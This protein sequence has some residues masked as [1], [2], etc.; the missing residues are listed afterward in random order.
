MKS[1]IFCIAL[2]AAALSV[3]AQKKISHSEP[4]KITWETNPVLH[5]VPPEYKNEPAF[6]LIDDESLD[7]RYEGGNINVYYTSHYLVKVLNDQGIETFNTRGIP[8][9]AGTRVPLIKARTIMPDGKVADV[10]KDMI[11]VT[12]D[13]YGRYKIVFAME[14]VA[15]NAEIEVLINEIKP[16]SFFGS[17]YFQYSI[18]V[19]HSSFE[20]S[21][22]KYM[23]FEEKGY[24]GYPTTKDTLLNN[25]RHILLAKNNIP[26]LLPEKHSYYNLHRMRAEYRIVNFIDENENDNKK[27]FTWNDLGRELYNDHY[28]ITDKEKKAVNKYL[29][30]LGAAPGAKEF[31]NIKKIENGIKTGIVLY[32]WLPG[33][34]ADD[35]DTIIAK[36]SATASGYIK[37]FNACFAQ[38]GVNAQL[39][40]AYDRREHAFDSKFENWGNLDNYLF[41][42]PK[43]KKFLSPTNIY[44]RFPIVD[45]ELVGTKGIFCTIP[46]DGV[47]NGELA[48]IQPI[49]PLKENESQENVKAVV[50]FSKE[51]DPVVAVKYSYTGYPSTDVR[52][53][54][55][56]QPKDKM[57]ELLKKLVPLAEKP[58][59]IVNYTINNQGFENYYDNKPLEIVA[60]VNAPQLTGMAGNKY[61]F[62]VGEI[63]GRSE[64][65]YT[66]KDRRMPVDIDYPHS[67]NRFITINIP[68]GYK[69]QNLEALRMHA[70]FVDKDLVPVV[71]FTSDYAIKSD[72]K[73]GD[74]LLITVNEVYSQLHFSVGDYE[75]YRKVV[76][77][78]SDF[79]KVTLLL[80][81]KG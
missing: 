62:K 42:F 52:E 68:A 9:D 58:E 11:K 20:M 24:N 3:S 5:P 65:M 15:R 57:N 55:A 19:M 72:K 27:L 23:I 56:L 21:Y 50:S 25:R 32:G 81:K 7:Y 14:G 71:S 28:K 16:L 8:V 63:I 74:Q 73:N 2:S 64:E 76:N 49:T 46:P 6:F 44:C 78:A 79:N 66:D 26:A 48:A 38:A 80:G 10:A 39:G 67:L 61:L 59:N 69:V 34:K 13:E 75:R 37:L 29:S 17:A 45:E 36:K 4:K 77:T 51:M 31:E 40:K 18:P 70:D 35:L 60:T 33:E 22:P 54:L 41:H 12:R 30:D 1:T 47:T 53:E 43:Q